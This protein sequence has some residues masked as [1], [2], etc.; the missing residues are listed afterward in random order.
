MLS[1]FSSH[2]QH[3]STLDA[4]LTQYQD[5]WQLQAFSYLDLPWRKQAPELCAWLDGLS[6]EQ[7][8]SYKVEPARLLQTLEPML[9]NIS[10][11]EPL[12]R[13]P[14][15]TAAS[16][17]EGA[18]PSRFSSHIK[19]RKWQQIMAFEAATANLVNG[20]TIEWCAGKGHLGRLLAF[21]QQRPV[22]SVEWLPE[23]CK[24][25]QRLAEVNHLAIDYVQADVLSGTADTLL[26]NHDSVVALHA[27]GE[28]HLH[29]IRQGVKAGTKQ[30]A[31]APCCYHLIPKA[32][33][34][35]LSQQAKQ[36]QLCLSREAYSL[37]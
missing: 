30:L 21:K 6:P 11:L 36:S 29:L 14:N 37:C 23:L 4:L 18:I 32:H 26:S 5:Y 25:G 15:L 10:E 17:D 35:A 8:Q 34:Q 28:L 16:I 20:A 31:I 24:H 33:Y 1:N 7:V 13:F 2:N 3:F 22:T 27:C 9:P 19:G 12:S